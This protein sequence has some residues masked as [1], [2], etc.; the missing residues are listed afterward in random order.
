MNG[1][2]CTPPPRITLN[3]FVVYI[4]MYVQV[5]MQVCTHVHVCTRAWRF[6]DNLGCSSHTINLFL[7]YETGPR[8]HKLA[9]E[10]Q[11]SGF[12]CWHYKSHHTC[13]L[14]STGVLGLELENPR[15]C[16]KD[17]SEGFPQPNIEYLIVCQAL[18]K[19]QGTL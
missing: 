8:V 11:D 2:E 5:H 1:F 18:F 12:L 10:P 14:F 13:L 7:F 4:L 16:S 17:F 6:K 15:F 3:I 9:S 19:V